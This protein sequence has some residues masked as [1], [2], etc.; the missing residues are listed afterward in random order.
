MLYDPIHDHLLKRQNTLPDD[1][2][3]LQQMPP[4]G[5]QEDECDVTQHDIKSTENQA[6]VKS[7]SDSSELEDWLDS[8]I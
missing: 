1:A 8:V 3:Q 4:T 2:P 5:Q 7:E 6:T